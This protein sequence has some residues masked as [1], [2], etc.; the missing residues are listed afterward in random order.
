MQPANIEGMTWDERIATIKAEWLAGK[1]TLKELAERYSMSEDTIEKRS[2]RERWRDHKAELCGRI[3]EK[4]ENTL[5]RRAVAWVDKVLGTCDLLHNSLL[6]SH[7]QMQ[8]AADPDA[9]AALSLTLQRLSATARVN[10]GLPDS[11]RQIDVTTGGQPLQV[12]IMQ[13]LRHVGALQESGQL[14]TA[15]IDVHALVS[16]PIDDADI[17]PEPTTKTPVEGPLG[18]SVDGVL[19]S[20]NTNVAQP[21]PDAPQSQPEGKAHVLPTEGEGG[22]VGGG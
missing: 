9:L 3:A 18:S 7:N 21:S 13:T 14:N 15:T 16:E 17:Q 8:P 4:V 2:M 19:P 11:P 22:R 12:A 1:G 6:E 5:E 20:T 10:F